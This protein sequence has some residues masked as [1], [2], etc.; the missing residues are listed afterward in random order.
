M[1]ADAVVIPIVPNIELKRI[2]YATD[3]SEASWA[4]SANCFDSC[5]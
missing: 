1:K 5:A 4:A 3:F 2:L